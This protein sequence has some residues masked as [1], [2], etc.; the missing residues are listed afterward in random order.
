[1]QIY[2][3]DF[4]HVKQNFKVAQQGILLC[5][6]TATKGYFS[7]ELEKYP[8]RQDLARITPMEETWYLLFDL[9]DNYLGRTQ[10]VLLARKHRE[11][12]GKVIVITDDT[13]SVY[14][15]K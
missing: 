10:D 4:T 9:S 11:E 14:A 8:S 5:I 1:M 7:I 12:G 3:L 6:K 2:E 13:M 15:E